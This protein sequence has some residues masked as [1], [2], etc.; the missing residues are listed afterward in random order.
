MQ[1][2]GRPFVLFR[3]DVDM[4]LNSDWT[5]VAT[6]S[7]KGD[8]VD[9]EVGREARRQGCSRGSQIEVCVACFLMFGSHF[10]M[11]LLCRSFV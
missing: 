4:S 9:D 11:V 10:I 5:E 2:R 7:S 6:S 3:Q 8:A 1:Y